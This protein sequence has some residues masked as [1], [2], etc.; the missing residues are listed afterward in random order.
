MSKPKPVAVLAGNSAQF[1]EYARQNPVPKPIF[2]HQW[3]DFGGIEFSKLVMVGTFKKRQDALEIY[4]R[5]LPMV[6][7]DAKAEGVLND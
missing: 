5:V 7:P 6:R 3:P 1:Y 2:C 4:S